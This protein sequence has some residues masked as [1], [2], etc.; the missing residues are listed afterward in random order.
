ME[1]HPGGSRAETEAPA[2]GE[3]RRQQLLPRPTATAPAAD[4]TLVRSRLS[5]EPIDPSEL[6]NCLCNS[7][8]RRR[9]LRS[10]KALTVFQGLRN[11]LKLQQLAGQ[12]GEVHLCLQR[13]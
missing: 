1:P 13:S 11:I 3:S 10:R 4:S 9:P 12:F 7:R 6:L 5:N 8:T 2:Q